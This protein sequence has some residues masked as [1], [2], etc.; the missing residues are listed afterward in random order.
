[1]GKLRFYRQCQDSKTPLWFH[2]QE[3]LNNSPRKLSPQNNFSFALAFVYLFSFAGEVS[4]GTALRLAAACEMNLVSFFVVSPAI[5]RVSD[6]YNKKLCK[7]SFFHFNSFLVTTWKAVMCEKEE[8][9][10]WQIVVSNRI[11]T[12]HKCVLRFDRTRGANKGNLCTYKRCFAKWNA[13]KRKLVFRSKNVLIQKRSK[14][15]N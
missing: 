4:T 13:S 14:I 9:T 7:I 10:N 3:T 5:V 6:H 2:S 12:A 11:F 15:T 8:N 1:M